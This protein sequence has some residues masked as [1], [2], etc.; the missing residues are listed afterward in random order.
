MLEL[1]RGGIALGERQ[2]G[3]AAAAA[4]KEEGGEHASGCGGDVHD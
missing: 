3:T 2:A 1:L 4:Q